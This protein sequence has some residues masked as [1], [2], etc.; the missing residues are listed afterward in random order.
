MAG[1]PGVIAKGLRIKGEL[2]GV[3]DLVIEGQVEGKITMNNHLVIEPSG[4][5]N[6]SIEVEKI[7]VRANANVSGEIRA[8]TVILEDGASFRGTIQMDVGI[9]EDV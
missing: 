3:G 9:P 7:T 8:P 2:T 6:A 4:V 1:S 5:V